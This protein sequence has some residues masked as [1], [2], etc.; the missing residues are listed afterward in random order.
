MD[1]ELFKTIRHAKGNYKKLLYHRFVSHLPHLL[2]TTL[3]VLYAPKIVSLTISDIRNLLHDHAYTVIASSA[4]LAFLATLYIMSRPRKIYLVEVAAF[5]PC[6]EHMVTRSFTIKQF[7]E[8]GDFLEESLTFQ[9]KML[10]RAGLGES[11]YFPMSLVR[12]PVNL[13]LA[14][15]RDEAETVIFGAVNEIF[16][17]TGVAAKDIGVLIVNSSLY[18]PTPSYTSMIVN[19]YKLRTNIITYNLGGMGCSAGL[20]AVDLAKSLLKVRMCYIF[21]V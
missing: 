14:N 8:C 2:L 21:L 13:C 5:K 4:L 12:Q 11:T 3:I 18:S 10:E 16:R 20:I 15:A 17:K 19:R 1:F 7:A 6:D 9:R